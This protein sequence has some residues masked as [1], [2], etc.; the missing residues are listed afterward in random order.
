MR[1]K[2]FA[3]LL[4][5]L[6]WY[7]CATSPDSGSAETGSTGPESITVGGDIRVRGQY[8]K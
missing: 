6:F 5:F 8:A 2:L 1:K 3:M 7:G 4:L